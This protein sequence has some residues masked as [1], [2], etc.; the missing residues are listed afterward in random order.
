MSLLVETIKINNGQ[1]YRLPLHNDRLNRSRQ[2]LYGS[3]DTIDLSEFIIV[4]TLYQTGLYKCRVL[5]SD[6][7]SRVELHPYSIRPVHSLK[8][9]NDDK[10]EYSLKS[11]ERS[12]LERLYHQRGESDDILIIKAG[13]LTDTYYGNVALKKDGLWYTPE[14]PLLE[15]TQRAALIQSGTIL[16]REI[17]V[18]DLEQYEQV[19]LFNAMIEFG[20]I[21]FDIT[22][23]S[24]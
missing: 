11:S 22:N 3:T 4:P 5:Y 13:Y 7:I 17:K 16:T 2:Q 20:Q 15:G 19:C 10:I 9:I 12:R 21:A 23:I 1:I 6:R 18:V 24:Y 8:L 14:H